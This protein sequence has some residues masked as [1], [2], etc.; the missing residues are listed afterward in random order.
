MKK[1]QLIVLSVLAATLACVV[2]AVPA[3]A[4]PGD[5]ALLSSFG[6]FSAPQAVGADAATGDVYVVDAGAGNVQRFDAAGNPHA[7]AALGTNV[8]DGTSTPGGGFAFAE[9]QVAVD[10][11]GGAT[12]G[13]IYVANSYYGVVDVFKQNGEYAGQLTGSSLPSPYSLVCGVAV[14]GSGRV[15]VSGGTA[16]VDRYVPT[17]GVVTDSDY[18]AQLVVGPSCPIAVDSTG[19]VYTGGGTTVKYAASDFGDPAPVGAEIDASSTSVAVDPLNDE[20]LVDEGTQIA[21]YSSTGTL[22]ATFGSSKIGSSMGL[23][24]DGGHNVL[25]VDGTNLNVHRFGIPTPGPPIVTA[26]PAGDVRPANATLRGSV[27]PQADTT[28]YHFEYGTDTSYGTSVPIPAVDLGDSYG[29][30]PVSRALTGLLPNTAYHYRV[31]ATNAYGTVISADRTFA[32]APATPVTATAV[33]AVGTELHGAVN[34]R[35][36]LGSYHF[37]YGTDTTYGQT[38]PE[39]SAGSVNAVRDVTATIAKLAPSTTYH[40]RLV[41]TTATGAVFSDDVTFTTLPAPT[42]TVADPTG[43]G[44]TAATLHG[45][46]DA[47]GVDGGTY[48]FFVAGTTNAYRSA[49]AATAIPAGSG[50]R[51]VA[52]TVGDLP[53]GGTYSVVFAATVAGATTYGTALTFSTGEVPR[54]APVPPITRPPSY[55]C[56]A[57]QIDPLTLECGASANTLPNVGPPSNRATSKAKVTGSRATLTITVP[58]PGR[59]TVGGKGLAGRTVTVKA[60]GKVTVSVSLTA[61]SK[62]ALKRA[63]RGKLSRPATI[64]FTPTGG[65]AARTKVALTFTRG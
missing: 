27:D 57:S 18:D 60:K 52:V 15:Y 55:P 44:A 1:L 2:C 64:T 30:L 25:V 37:E 32:T 16:T 65:T 26:D 33:G 43:V 51:D 22:L 5:Y 9:T 47:H 19:A 46:V 13:A 39:R 10:R 20:V 36:A 49:T 62:R 17:G 28:T 8:L 38:T 14:D 59:L 34:P 56:D 24:V 35:G 23:A 3:S 54:A 50:P 63:K 40:A 53:A 29:P 58:G 12:D 4:A 61:Q 48:R 7:F 6:A 21:R 42:V 45:T 31:V 11:S 41:A